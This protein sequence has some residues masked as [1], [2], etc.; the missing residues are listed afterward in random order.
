MA[1]PLL[2]RIVDRWLRRAAA[3]DSVALDEVSGL[4][5]AVVITGGT[6]GI[7]LALA[8]L[9]AQQGDH[10][11]V[12]IARSADDLEREVS[13][14]VQ[15]GGAKVVGLALD[16]TDANA[17]A[18][19]SKFLRDSGLFLDVLVNSAGVGH[20]GPFE[21]QPDGQ[22]AELI[23]LNVTALSRLNRTFL[24]QLLARGRG[25]ILNI[26]SLGGLLPGPGQASYYASKAYVISLTE[27]LAW[28]VR[29]RGVRV[30]AVAPG[31]VDTG[32]HDTMGAEGSLYRWL[33]PQRSPE[34]VARVAWRGFMLGQ[35]LI[36]PGFFET[37]LAF[38]IRFMP[39][40]VVV[41]V[42]GL[43]LRKPI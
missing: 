18:D 38:S 16:I 3:P 39:R 28:E 2:Y 22:L 24:P 7:G 23:E 9:L 17:P 13:S 43:L 40:T 25:G 27:A 37:F 29:G 36:V 32:F 41:A 42:V 15:I 26:A 10:A 33:L 34:M 12:L 30:A 5:P 20:A 21:A 35:T 1:R 6:R 4:I 11:V 14:L 31:P 8:R 19:L